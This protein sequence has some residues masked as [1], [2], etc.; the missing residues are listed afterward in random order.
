MYYINF[1]FHFHWGSTLLY[2]PQW[3]TE[4]PKIDQG[5]SNLVGKPNMAIF[6]YAT[7]AGQPQE[8]DKSQSS[9]FSNGN[10]ALTSA[11][12]PPVVLHQQGSFP[13]VDVAHLSFPAVT[14]IP[15]RSALDQR[16]ERRSVASQAMPS[17]KKGGR[18]NSK[19]G[20]AN[21][22]QAKRIAAKRRNGISSLTCPCL[23]SRL[24]LS[25]F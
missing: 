19:R 21:R 18:R 2:L 13:D 7:E 17:P 12:S 23:T 9:D 3:N 25:P 15:R 22:E 5:Q 1:L 6:P 11:Q 10:R 16:P 20:R 4:G 24:R 14:V 8:S